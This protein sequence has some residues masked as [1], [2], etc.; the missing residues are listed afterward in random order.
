MRDDDDGKI[1]M[2][3]DASESERDGVERSKVKLFN[4]RIRS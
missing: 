1:E 4:I 3:I 2:E